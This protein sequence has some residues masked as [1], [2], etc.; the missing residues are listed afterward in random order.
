MLELQVGNPRGL[1]FRIPFWF[2]LSC[3]RIPFLQ[4]SLPPSSR[5][6]NALYTFR[7]FF[8]PRGSARIHFS[9]PIHSTFRSRQALSTAAFRVS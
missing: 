8:I 4:A 5:S 3:A 1:L 7:D 6:L 9:P 2:R